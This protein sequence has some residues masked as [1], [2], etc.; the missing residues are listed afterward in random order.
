MK[1]RELKARI[2]YLLE[3]LS[4]LFGSAHADFIRGK[5][6][7]WCSSR[8]DSVQPQIVGLPVSTTPSPPLQVWP[9]SSSFLSLFSHFHHYMDIDISRNKTTFERDGCALALLSFSP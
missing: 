3:G 1:A 7:P 5:L 4:G 6:T 2:N 8:G 9:P